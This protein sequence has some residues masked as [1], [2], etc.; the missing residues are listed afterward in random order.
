MNYF[1]QFWDEGRDDKYSS[2]GNSTWY[3][4][5]NEKDEILKQI[6]VYQNEKILKYSKENPKD[7][8][9]HLGNHSLTI[10][11]CDGDVITKEDFYKLW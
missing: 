5:T 2:W 11:D 3:F 9:G 7:E 6:T 1:T 8:F 10:E 4:E